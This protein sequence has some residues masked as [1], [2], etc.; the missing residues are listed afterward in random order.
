MILVMGAMGNMGK[1]TIK[2]KRKLCTYHEYIVTEVKEISASVFTQVWKCRF[3]NHPL[4]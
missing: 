2:P 4:K 3:C 1:L